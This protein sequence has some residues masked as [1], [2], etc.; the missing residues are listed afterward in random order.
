MRISLISALLVITAVLVPVA[1]EDLT[2]DFNASPL[3]G[4]S[5][6]DVQ[7][8]DQSIGCVTSWLWYFGDEYSTNIRNPLHRYDSAGD[9]T[10]RLTVANASGSNA[11]EKLDYIHVTNPAPVADFSGD[12]VTGPAPLSVQFTDTSTG[13]I[14][15][16]QWDFG[17]GYNST[18]SD[19]FHIFNYPGSYTVSLTV[20]NDGGSN[21]RTLTDYINVTTTPPEADFSANSTAGTAPHHVLFTD[22]SSGENITQWSWTFG[23]GGTSD[24]TNPVHVYQNA[25]K[26]SVSL[27][28]GNAGGP[29]TLTR[30]E[31][32]RVFQDIPLADFYADPTSGGEPL[33]VQFYDTSLGAPSTWYWQFGDGGVSALQ[34]PSH[35]YQNPGLYTVSLT[36]GSSGGINTTIKTDYISV[37]QQIPVADFSAY[38][39]TGAIP[40]T[41]NFTDQSSGTPTS[42]SW[43]FGDGAKSESQNPSHQ[44]MSPG[45]F[46]VNLTVSNAHGSHSI[47]KE[48]YIVTGELPHANFTASTTTPH[49]SEYIDFED[50]STGDPIEY[51][52]DFGDGSTSSNQNPWHW[53]QDPGNYTVSLHV[54]NMFGDDTEIKTDYIHVTPSPAEAWFEGD[55]RDGSF[56]L[57]VTFY[58]WSYGG[59]Y[60]NLSYQWDFGDGTP[61]STSSAQE[62]VHTY[63]EAGVY[64]VTLTVSADS[65]SS[66]YQR[67]NYIGS[68]SPPPP[69]AGFTATPVSGNAPMSVSFIDQ[70]SGS[71]PLSY[72]WDFGDSS[73]S[74]EKNPVHTYATAGAYNVTLTTTNAGG[75][76]IEFKENYISVGSVAP[77]VAEFSSNVTSGALPLSVHFQDASEGNPSS[78]YWNF[79]GSAYYVL[80]EVT[81]NDIEMY[82]SR[83]PSTEKDPVVVY[84]SPGNYTVTLTVSRT[85]ETDTIEKVDYIQVTPPPPVADFYGYNREGPA[86]LTV[87]FDGYISWWYYYDEFIWDFGDGTSATDTYP[88][89]EHTYQDPGLYNVTLTV[90]SQYGNDTITKAGYVNVTQP[91]PPVPSFEAEPLSG[92]APL[93]V[94]FSDTSEGIVTSR[95]WDYGDGTSEWVNSSTE[96]THMYAIPGIYTVSLTA[97]N[98]GGQATE[99]KTDYISVNPSGSPPD[100]QFSAVPGTGSAPLTVYFTDAS[101]GSPSRWEW[102]FGDGE[103]SHEQN[104][105]H[106]Y[107]AAG[108]YT[109][110]LTV[111]NSGGS[112]SI[113]RIIWVRA[114]RPPMAF[115]MTDKSLGKAPMTVQFTDRSY[116]SPTSWTWNFGDGE[117]SSLRNP[118][119]TYT[120]PGTYTATLTVQNGAGSSSTSRRLYVR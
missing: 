43:N 44:Y 35:T 96:T 5:P 116:N 70:S 54:T 75:S 79:G 100:A 24:E 118:T 23:D 69:V 60:D 34:S 18:D 94:E 88:W 19:P 7:F 78:W 47:Q 93:A 42:W 38:P 30:D 85:G 81:T 105:S 53:Y 33:A 16:Y 113:S 14:T 55:P 117:V 1:A 90:T 111:Y 77:L 22:A 3:F 37:S 62:V 87:E 68:Q 89:I 51:L 106:T 25:G 92:D 29:N 110:I 120:T 72:T 6:L 48:D 61:N 84:E 32:I 20:S 64:T 28:V 114:P 95:L 45:T 9:Y 101:T 80:S 2:A 119:H 109:A 63:M 99:T 103:T 56:P 91:Q 46:T 57:T 8:T 12:P 65:L 71:P 82:S 59:Y 73:N 98:G 40:L 27:T 49:T 13:V 36:A 86:P 39:T 58:Q 10:V 21:T 102:S 66:T 50:L 108:R 17:D 41:V 26:Y 74:T 31:Y 104:P 4:E 15:G 112:D 11:T 52:W 107:T 67:V 76:S 97:G 83:Q 115:F